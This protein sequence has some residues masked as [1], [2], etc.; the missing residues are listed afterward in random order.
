MEV[1][2]SGIPESS[3]LQRECQSK[4]KDL[5]KVSNAGRRLLPA[6]RQIGKPTH[7]LPVG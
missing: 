1:H 3:V 4:E 6:E 5:R 2:L 7:G